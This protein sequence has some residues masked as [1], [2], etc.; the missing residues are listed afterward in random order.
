MPALLKKASKAARPGKRI[1]LI[2]E[3]ASTWAAPAMAMAA[4][5]R[6]CSHCCTLPSIAITSAEA[7]LLASVTGQAMELPAGAVPVQALVTDPGAAA[8]ATALAFERAGRESLQKQPFV[9]YLIELKR[10]S[11]I[12]DPPSFAHVTCLA[13]TEHSFLAV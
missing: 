11:Q 13:R 3:A 6:G 2:L 1:R 8:A 9:R 10:D 12:P 7:R 5:R 4:C